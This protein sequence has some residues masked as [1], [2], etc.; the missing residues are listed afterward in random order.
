MISGRSV[1]L[2]SDIEQLLINFFNQ[3]QPNIIGI[4]LGG[5]ATSP[6][7]ENPHDYDIFIVWANPEE[8]N[9][10]IPDIKILQQQRDEID[11]AYRFINRHIHEY[12]NHNKR[13]WLIYNYLFPYN[14]LIIG[15]TPYT[16]FIDILTEWNSIYPELVHSIKRAHY[17]KWFYHILTTLYIWKNQSYELTPEQLTNVQIVHDQSNSQKI[18]E[19]YQWALEELNKYK[20]DSE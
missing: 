16:V 19:L 17:Q 15:E 5:S 7:I 11:S 9:N 1:R 4:F 3:H 12:E 6:Y 13:H 18:E 10:A 20:K 2:N 14:Q 8:R